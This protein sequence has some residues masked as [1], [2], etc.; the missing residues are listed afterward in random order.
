MIS[1]LAVNEVHEGFARKTY[2][3]CEALFSR[4]IGEGQV[5]T[6]VSEASWSVGSRYN[7]E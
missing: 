4:S 7:R 2:N 3:V 6:P 1:D 5:R